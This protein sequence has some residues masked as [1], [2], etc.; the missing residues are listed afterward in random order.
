MAA[1]ALLAAM[2]ASAQVWRSMGPPGGDVRSLVS[3]PNHP[4]VL[5]LGTADGQVFTSADDGAH[6]AMA[7]RVGRRLDNVVAAIIVD[8]RSSRRLYAGV[9]SLNPS[10]GGGVYR[11]EDGGRNWQPLG[12][13]GHAV[14]AL[15]QSASDPNIL[16]AG[17]LDGVFRSIDGGKQWQ[18]IS[19]AGSGEIRNLDSVAI[20]PREP[21]T[22]YAG[23]YHLPWKT[24]DGG[25]RWFPIHAGMIDDSDVFSIAIDPLRPRLVYLSSCSGIYRSYNGGLQWV[26]VQGIPTSARRTQVIVQDPLHRATVYA[27]TTEGLWKT[28]SGG[29]SWHR[30]TPANWI[31]NALVVDPRREGRIIIGTERLGVLVSSNGGRTYQPSN[32]GF[33]HREIAA[34]ALD[35]ARPGRVLAILSDAPNPVVVTDNGG[36]SWKPLG[37]NLRW[38]SVRRLYAA[39]NGWLAALDKGGLLRYDP[40][41]RSWVRSGQLAGEAAWT[42][43]NGRLIKPDR[44]PFD[45]VVQDMAF[46]RDGWYAATS[47][48]LL[49]SDDRGATWSEVRFAPLILPVQSVA[50]S[51]GG[52]R[53]WVATEH[54]MVFSDNGGGSWNWRDLP[55]SAGNVVRLEISDPQSLLTLTTRG[56]YISYDGGTHW[57]RAAHGLPEVAI[58]DVAVAGKTLLASVGVGGLFISRDRG[59]TW[60]PVAGSLAEGN[61]PVVAAQPGSNLI[62]AASASSGL[63]SIQL[64][65]ASGADTIAASSDPP[66]KQR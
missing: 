39:P 8:P 35:R 53:L 24:V 59:R 38:E 13:A 11:S 34:V 64:G 25:K 42:F 14:R 32:D 43:Q 63:Y 29:A 36:V 45:L 28:T 9:W 4:S 20:D 23:T 18:R 3:D 55:S 41:R 66:Q 26:K 6:W 47:Y 52:K 17:A 22:I 27:G 30:M 37:A 48:G 33:N 7:G 40:A 54:G 15:A 56:L 46:S 62:Y 58:R 50:V 51:P 60:S 65:P 16:V 19:P 44:R 12:L 57:T 2:P 61:F 10:G 49:R 31:I 5:Y 21:R 1:F